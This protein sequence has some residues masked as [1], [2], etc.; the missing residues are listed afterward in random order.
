[1]LLRNSLR[2]LIKGWSSGTPIIVFNFHRI[3]NDKIKST[4]DNLHTTSINNFT[5]LL[6]IYKTIFNIINISQLKKKYKYRLIPRALIT[7]DDVSRSFIENALPILERYHLPVAIFPCVSHSSKGYGWRDL[8]YY[9]M[10]HKEIES[11][12]VDNVFKVLGESSKKMIREMGIYSWSKQVD[13]HPKWLEENILIPAIDKHIKDFESEVV[14]IKPYLNWD[15]LRNISG[16]PLIIIGNHGLNHWDYQTLNSDEIKEDIIQSHE[17]FKSE[18]GYYPEHFALPFGAIDQKVFLTLDKLLYKLGYKTACWGDGPY[19]NVITG[20][21]RVIHL[22]RIHS[23]NRL[24]QSLR[25]CLRALSR[26]VCSPVTVLKNS[27]PEGNSIVD[28]IISEDEYHHIHLLIV[29]KKHHHQ[30][31]EYYD[32]LFKLNPY[33]SQNMPIHL[34]MRYDG[35][36]EAIASLFHVC[37]VLNGKITNGAYFSGWWRMPE[38]HSAEG[39]RP[40]LIK[41]QEI[42]PILGAYS[43]SSFSGRLFGKA[44]WK[45]IRGSRYEGIMKKDIYNTDYKV[46]SQFP[47]QVE[48]LL[49]NFNSFMNLSIWRDKIYYTWRYDKYPL[50][51]FVYLVDAGDSPTWFVVIGNQNGKLF[52]SD[53]IAC[54]FNDE[55]GWRKTMEAVGDYSRKISA[56]TISIETS[57]IILQNLSEEYG[58]KLSK[59]YSNFYYISSD[60]QSHLNFSWKKETIIHETQATGDVLPR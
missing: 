51:K 27:R 29:P 34:G 24:D 13:V 9:I 57:N 44:G 55:I 15:D 14:K 20:E 8:I 32:Y 17:I 3:A 36:L 59:S 21:T 11:G 42:C 47:S 28:T 4:F 18:L 2:T 16:N 5:S 56:K 50:L 58:L 25:V 35:N 40:L 31:K 30:S 33:V 1:M 37:F 23:P 39:T 41:A 6:T 38:V 43:A 46:E 54:P 49:N 60:L 12:V 7:F 26:P 52:L 10:E 48:T 53:C 19:S 45:E 22:F